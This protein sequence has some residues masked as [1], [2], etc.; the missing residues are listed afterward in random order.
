MSEEE[1]KW[2]KGIERDSVGG[3]TLKAEKIRRRKAGPTGKEKEGL[4]I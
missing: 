1:K 4:R 2:K 3:K